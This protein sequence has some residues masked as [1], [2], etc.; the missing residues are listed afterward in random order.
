MTFTDLDAAFD[1]MEFLAKTTGRTHLL[2][3]R[4]K[5]GYRVVE[6][7]CQGPTGEVLAELNCRNVIGESELNARR[8]YKLRQRVVS[9]DKQRKVI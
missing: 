6:A 4:K 3:K 2:M 7:G 1:E 9:S 5:I 8:G